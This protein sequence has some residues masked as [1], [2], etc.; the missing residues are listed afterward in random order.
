MIEFHL[1]AR[2][3]GDAVCGY[4]TACGL[5]NLGNEVGFYTRFPEWFVRVKH[6]G[7]H[8]F[9]H[10]ETRINAN[11]GY[12]AQLVAASRGECASR[13]HWYAENIARELKIP[14]FEP[15]SPKWVYP[16]VQRRHPETDYVV[17]SPFSAYSD[18]EW[19]LQHWRRLGT[20]LIKAGCNIF[21]YAHQDQELRLR[22]L[23]TGSGVRYW[24]GQNPDWMLDAILG[25]RLLIGNDSGMVHVAGLHNK[26]A[27]VISAQ[28]DPDFV[29]R[30][31]DSVI[32][33]R[34]DEEYTCR[35]CCWQDDRGF[36]KWCGGGSNHG[37]GCSALMS[38]GSGRIKRIALDVIDSRI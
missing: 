1:C 28:I 23:F 8:V 37:E 14:V 22:G 7:V 2:G 16:P 27:I 21:A 19:P 20:D 15:A 34:P 24:W 13:S 6:P 17:L 10:K 9:P 32:R 31:A 5:A 26:K 36:M 25:C 38:I 33:V 30:E 12:A 4:R 3:V 35:G 11:I 29:F 18:R